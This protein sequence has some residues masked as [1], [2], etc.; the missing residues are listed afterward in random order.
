MRLPGTV[1]GSVKGHRL[2]Q[3]IIHMTKGLGWEGT[4]DGDWKVQRQSFL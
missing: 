4:A 2:A 3:G 1:Q